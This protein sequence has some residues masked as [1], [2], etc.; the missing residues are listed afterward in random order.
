V[1][2][3]KE[4]PAGSFMHDEVVEAALGPVHVE[5]TFYDEKFEAVKEADTAG[6]YGA[7]VRITL[8]DGTQMTRFITLY[9]VPENVVWQDI[10]HNLKI[11]LAAGNTPEAMQAQQDAIATV[12][13][14]AM[15]GE[16]FSPQIGAVLLGLARAA[17]GVRPDALL[18]GFM[19]RDD[20]WWFELRKRL[21]LAETYP[22]LIQLPD[23]YAS[24]PAHRW[25]LILFL[26]GSG[27]RGDSLPQLRHAGLPKLIAAG[28][29]FAAIVVSPQCPEHEWWSTPVLSQLIDDVSAKYQVDPDR[30]VV[31]GLSMGGF[32]TWALA[33]ASPDR[34]SA[35]APVCGG[36][37]AAEADRLVKLPV[38]AFHGQLDHTVPVQMSE[39]MTAAIRQAGGD[40]HLTIYPDAGHDSWTRA[41][42]TEALYV[43]L[44]AQQRGKPEVKTPGL[45]TP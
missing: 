23:G 11:P 39:V 6:R 34:F 38:W 15:G 21:G 30:V 37:N 41:Y 28:Q 8:G 4:F 40:P 27:E 7:V 24:D 9:R 12:L 10:G 26:H 32:A 31:T 35:I 18:F 29:K 14:D 1:F 36:G 3:T 44:L 42:S 25:P 43:W 22:Y 2:S 20:A 19:A 33:L 45:P 16:L 17:P 5:T 13:K